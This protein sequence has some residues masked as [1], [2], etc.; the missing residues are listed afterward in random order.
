MTDD[1][2]YAGIFDFGEPRGLICD[3]VSDIFADNC[4]SAVLTDNINSF[5]EPTP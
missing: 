2:I 3:V 4:F 1:V 5:Y